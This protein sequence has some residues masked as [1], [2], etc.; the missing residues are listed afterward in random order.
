MEIITKG[1]FL[2]TSLMDMEWYDPIMVKLTLDTLK[3]E[4][5]TAR[6]SNSQEVVILYSKGTG[7]KANL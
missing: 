6:G 1:M 4:E 5:C 2:E 3:T 7:P